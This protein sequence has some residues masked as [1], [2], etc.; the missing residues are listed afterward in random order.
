MHIRKTLLGKVYLSLMYN[1][2][3]C[4]L[5][6]KNADEDLK[7]IHTILIEKHFVWMVFEKRIEIL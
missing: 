2:F 7:T 3:Y 1:E 4:S 6:A 5:Y